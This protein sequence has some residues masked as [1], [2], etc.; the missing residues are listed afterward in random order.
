MKLTWLAY[1]YRPWDGYGRYSARLIQAL[2][3]AGVSVTPHF[4]GAADAPLWMQEAWGVDFNVPTISCLPP[5]YLRKLPRGSAPHWLLTMTEGSECP[6]GWAETINK[7]GVSRVVVP[8]QWNAEA[9]RSGGVECPISVIPGGTDPDEFPLLTERPER[10][11]TFLALA[12]RGGRKGYT[13]VWEAFYKAFGGKSTGIA[14][15]RL[16]VKSRP[17]GNALLN[18]HVKHAIGL[19]PRLIFNDS[20]VVNMRDLYAQ[21]DCFAIPSRA[22]GWGMPHREAAM[23]GLPVITQCYSGMDDG[24]TH[25]WAMVVEGGRMERVTTGKDKH[26]AGEWRRVD[27]DELA[28]KMR[29]CYDN[30]EQAQAKGQQAAKWLRANQTWDDSASALIALL[31]REGVLEMEYA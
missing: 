31:Q 26:I 25:E 21:A 10:P 22:E 23:C 4:A 8:C 19:D 9:F 24:H 20:D 6:D 5:F 12:D 18:D 15:V 7:A 11:Y 16:M 30:R 17:D 28:A 27:T 3:N 2:Q 29:W 1:S 13:D 14:D